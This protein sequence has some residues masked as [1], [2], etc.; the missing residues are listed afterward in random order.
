[1]LNA[2]SLKIEEYQKK[3]I[4]RDIKREA[5]SNYQCDLYN[6]DY[7]IKPKNNDDLLTKR[8]CTALSHLDRIFDIDAKY[9]G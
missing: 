9:D 4:T 6:R 5:N 7:V 3:Y 2:A 8:A 1:M